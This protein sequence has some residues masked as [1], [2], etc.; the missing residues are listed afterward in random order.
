MGGPP[1]LPPLAA[2]FLW[3]VKCLVPTDGA[4][5][6]RPWVSFHGALLK[7]PILGKVNVVKEP[8]ACAAGGLAIGL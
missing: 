2:A 8:V 3:H 5:W 7:L 4:A 6:R 1:N